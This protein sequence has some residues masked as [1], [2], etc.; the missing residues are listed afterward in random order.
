M[1]GAP[2]AYAQVATEQAPAVINDSLNKKPVS[3]VTVGAESVISVRIMMNVM[4]NSSNMQA[5]RQTVKST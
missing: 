3:L 2:Q 4:I 5:R 1:I